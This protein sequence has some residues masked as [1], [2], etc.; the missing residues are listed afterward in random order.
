MAFRHFSTNVVTP[1]E[2]KELRTAFG[3]SQVSFGARVG[4]APDVIRR[5][6][7]G[8]NRPHPIHR[9]TLRALQ[10]KQGA[11]EIKKEAVQ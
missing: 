3:E 7:Q 9:K 11:S 6:E 2:I 10:A 8:K 5:W 1:T 4:V